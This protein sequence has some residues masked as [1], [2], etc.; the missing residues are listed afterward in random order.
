MINILK[1]TI[2]NIPKQFWLELTIINRKI[3][4]NSTYLK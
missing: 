3:K 2:K 4:E 1:D